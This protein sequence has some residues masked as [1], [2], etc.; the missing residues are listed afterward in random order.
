MNEYVISLPNG[1]KVRTL[2]DGNGPILLL[3]HGNPDNADEW[4]P[5]ISFLKND[6]RCI[7]PDLPG[8]GRQGQ[9][10]PLPD[11]FDYSVQAQTGFIDA[12]LNSLNIRDKITLAVHDIG[13]IMGIPWAAQH[14]DRLN[15]MIYTNTV[16]YPN[17]KWFDTAYRW[18]N[19]SPS[20]RRIAQ[21]SMNA[22]GWLHGWLF[23]KIFSRQ[24]PQLT[25]E[26]ID[27]FVEDFALNPIAKDTTL[28]EFRQITKPDFFNGYDRMLKTIAESIP[29]LTMWGKGDPYV[30]DRFANELQ[31]QKTLLMPDVGHWVPLVAANTM[32]REIQAL[33]KSSSRSK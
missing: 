5:L 18:G 8:Y 13:G 10:Y 23:K 27:R 22:I 15:A 9:T 24:H 17:F 19:D 6:F 12:L 4:K 7:A 32:A 2:D 20:G 28:C 14:P 16:A 3:L 31:A 1:I 26:Q 21:V 29:T 30:P 33:C 25:G 11:C